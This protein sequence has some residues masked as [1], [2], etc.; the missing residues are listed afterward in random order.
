MADRI[1]TTGFQLPNH[2]GLSLD[3]VRFIA[4]TALDAGGA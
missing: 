4:K 1:H 2:P 3:D